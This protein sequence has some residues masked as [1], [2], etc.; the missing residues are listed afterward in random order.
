[1]VD[2]EEKTMGRILWAYLVMAAVGIG[3]FVL[4][5]SEAV[6]IDGVFNFISALSMIAGMKIARL[7]SLKPTQS[8]PL[9]YAMYETLYT[10]TKGVMIVGILLLA[11]SSNSIKI[12]DYI[13]TGQVVPIN[14]DS[15]LA[16]SACMVTLCSIVYIYLRNQANRVKNQSIMLNTEKI[17]I[18]QNAVISGAIGVV[19]LLVGFMKNTPLECIIP[20]TDSIVVLILCILMISDPIKIIKNAF[21]ELTIRD[22]HLSLREKTGKKIK[23]LL[24]E[25]YKMKQVQINR[26]GRTY[27]F[28][29]SIAPTKDTLTVDEL[30]TIKNTISDCIKEDAPINFTD[31]LFTR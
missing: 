15:I 29:I 20:V 5:N 18:F 28:V 8:Q 21:F 9:G 2:V 13:T 11:V 30:D 12:Y 7:L 27:F 23:E 6:L 14:G 16:Y 10:L 3:T 31:I 24:P 4:S 26:L 25:G 22:S 1:M 17:A 19:F